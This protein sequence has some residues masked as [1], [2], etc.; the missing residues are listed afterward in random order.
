M[1]RAVI[2]IGSNTVKLL[3]A[4]I[5]NGQIEPVV[6]KDTTTRLGERVD[7]TKRLSDPAISRTIKAINQ[8]VADARDLGAADVLAFTTSAARD[9]V[10]CDEF[11]NG[12]RD[13]CDLD[14]QVISGEREAELI[15]RGAASDP[16]WANE[17][18]L[19]MDVGGGSAEW[20]LGQRDRIEH[21]LSL[22]LGAVRLT[23]RF[24]HRDFAELAAYLR[25][26]LRHAL[27]DY[28]GAAWRMIG[29]G[30]SATTL[31]RVKRGASDR[32]TLSV[33]DLRSLVSSLEAMTL[34]ERKRVP[35]L[36]PERADI[37]VAGGAVFLFAMEA[38]G[39]HE[40]TVSVRSL[41][42]GALFV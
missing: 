7:E 18:I 28:A 32:V 6:A 37:I 22:P 4:D 34:D 10:N 36:P 15:F 12:V 5:Q 27:G 35:G 26:T 41:R 31:A 9:A 14:A 42:Y 8:Y 20:I 17:R 19:V 24:R 38:L 16:A 23:E 3:V 30:G 21:S 40:L 33:D 13:H 29:T 11:L 2:D 1:R 25:D 39:A